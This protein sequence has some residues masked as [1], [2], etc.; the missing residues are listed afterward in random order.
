MSLLKYIFILI[1]G[2]F[3]VN[4]IYADEPVYAE[5]FPIDMDYDKRM[6]II[7]FQ[8]GEYTKAIYYLELYIK[9]QP[10]DE[11][12]ADYLYGAYIRMNRMSQAK[13]I[14]PDLSEENRRTYTVRPKYLSYVYLEGGL[15]GKGNIKEEGKDIN[16]FFFFPEY[17]PGSYGLLQLG[18]DLTSQISYK[19][20]CSFYTIDGIQKIYLNKTI[21]DYNIDERQISYSGSLQYSHMT[22]WVFGLCGAY[23][24]D[25]Y[26]VIEV[27]SSGTQNNFQYPTDIWH[28]YYGNWFYNNHYFWGWNNYLIPTTTD[29]AKDEIRNR[30]ETEHSFGVELNVK[31]SFDFILPEL[32]FSYANISNINVWQPKVK[33]TLFPFHTLN[34]YATTTLSDIIYLQSNNFIFEE[35]IGG[36]ITDWLW[37]EVAYANGNMKFYNEN[38]FV[39]FY[40]MLNKSRHRASVKTYFPLT[41]NLSLNLLYRIMTK[42][43]GFTITNNKGE[44]STYKQK[45][46]S[47]NIIGGIKWTF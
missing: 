12:A 13:A 39:T 24:N 42:E 1:L 8:N 3:C 34:L 23:F 22:G 25:K 26:D 43:S 2:L 30:T 47:H 11:V 7:E 15:L 37:Y 18:H 33:F 10:Q 17:E 5:E 36:R 27:K 45:S 4:D 46:N 32:H 9:R 21:E 44:T 6:G 38:D 28:N 20:H 14:Y 19:H 16:K 29:K 35:V 31:K 40:T 41:S